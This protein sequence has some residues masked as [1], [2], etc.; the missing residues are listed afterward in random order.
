MA[1]DMLTA[2]DS[3]LNYVNLSKAI[4]GVQLYGGATVDEGFSNSVDLGDMAVKTSE[5]VGNT[6]D[7][8]INTLNETVLYRVCGERKANST[9]LALYYPLWENND[10]LQEYMEISNSVKYKEFLLKICNR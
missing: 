10:E 4:S 2:T 9:G 5:F 1:G 7:V 6:S 8:L 3:L